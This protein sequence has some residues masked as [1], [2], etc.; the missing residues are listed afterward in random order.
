MKQA[1]EQESVTS[2]VRW[3]RIDEHVTSTWIILE[4]IAEQK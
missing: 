2:S 1:T 4:D 3:S